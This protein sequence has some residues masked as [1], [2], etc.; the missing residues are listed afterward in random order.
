MDR[1]LM[2]KFM[3]VS[4]RVWLGGIF[5]FM[6]ALPA[7]AASLLEGIELAD[8]PA[9][10]ALRFDRDV[11]WRV[12]QTGPRELVVAL[13]SASVARDLARSGS[14]L[15]VVQRI[16]Y[17]RTAEGD[18]TLIVETGPV[19]RSV[20]TRWRG[21]VRI[22]EIY[23]YPEIQQAHK[24]PRG[25]LEQRRRVDTALKKKPSPDP[26]ADRVAIARERA[27]AIP[28]KTVQEES[29]PLDLEGYGGIDTL[30]DAVLHSPCGGGVHVRVAVRN[31]REGMCAQ[32]LDTLAQGLMDGC[33]DVFDYLRAWCDFDRAAR[34]MEQ[35]T[36]ARNLVSLVM[37]NPGSDYLPW[38]YAMLGVLY[39]RMG[40]DPMGMGYFELLREK[41][42][43]FSG[44]PEILL[45]LGRMYMRI[46][47]L[48]E[49]EP[50]LRDLVASYG[51]TV[52]AMDARMELGRL[53]FE[54]KRYFDTLKM[55]ETLIRETPDRIFKDKDLL[56][57]VG[58]SHFHTG[59]YAKAIESLTRAYNDFPDMAERSLVLT[60]IADSYSFLEEKDK[61]K[62]LYEIVRELFPGTDGFVISSIRLAELLEDREK[63]NEL[64]E[65]VIRDYPDH[66]LARLA[67][68]RLA[69]S[70]YESGEYSESV[71]LVRRLLV[72][73]PRALRRGALDLMG[74]SLEA[75]FDEFLSAGLYPEVIRRYEREKGP[76][77]DIE[78]PELHAQVGR[79]F[80]EG[81][82]YPQ[83]VNQYRRAEKLFGGASVPPEIR[84]R[85]GVAAKGAGDGEMAL[86]QLT[87]FLRAVPDDPLRSSLALGHIGD[88]RLEMGEPDVAL[89]AYQDAA[90]LAKVDEKKVAF[91]FSAAKI[92]RD[93][94][95]RQKEAEILEK[96]LAFSG[97]E[98]QDSTDLHFTILRSLGEAR[99]AQGKYAKAA[100][101]YGKAE[102]IPGIAVADRNAVRFRLAETLERTGDTVDARR[103]YEFLIEDADP[104]WGSMARERLAGMRIEDKL[105]DS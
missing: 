34:P 63:K 53:L 31:I 65:M 61:A 8:N 105:L 80:L 44:M 23:L 33:G 96:A 83:A 78:K 9:R 20:E 93:K 88:I 71:N 57:L 69:E 41:D 66:P 15:P 28:V 2:V 39:H 67:L 56:L 38:A 37:K 72:A 52:F 4:C 27:E 58:N 12:F 100:A 89:K 97:V 29:L 21:G 7:A 10:I 76:L 55:L 77:Y 81:H 98:S 47:R 45:Y 59:S 75:L 5:F 13:A 91:L 40:N 1:V 36:L 103:L 64:F 102:A 17:K 19:I 104:L 99:A 92:L 35:L 73:D 24:V 22:L 42:P 94:G 60:R 46:Q 84:F 101:A 11:Q 16:V 43:E 54:R 74:R 85:Y 14:A 49:A 6:L 70:R 48:E 90:S 26:E 25:S 68:M 62:K 30:L 18:A 3:K 86:A 87:L 32:G 51:D 79:A 82:L 50:L 95:Q